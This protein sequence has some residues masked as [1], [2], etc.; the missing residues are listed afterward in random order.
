MPKVEGKFYSLF[1]SKLSYIGW[2]DLTTLVYCLVAL[3]MLE[4]SNQNFVLHSTK[5]KYIHY[6]GCL[7]KMYV[8]NNCI[9]PYYQN[10]FWESFLSE[11]R[12]LISLN[13][14]LKTFS[15]DSSKPYQLEKKNK[16][17]KKKILFM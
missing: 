16:G 14:N 9:H 10:G 2:V 6:T 1:S 4:L 3:P 7:T 15:R 8:Y 5:L 13:K 17:K 11:Q 12:N